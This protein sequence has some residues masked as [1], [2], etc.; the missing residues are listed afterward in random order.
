MHDTQN[1]TTVIMTVRHG[2]TDFNRQRRYAGLLDVSLNEDGIRDCQ[3]AAEFL[4]EPYDVVIASALK[5]SIETARLLVGPETPIGECVLCNE[6]NFGTM[7]GRTAREVEAIRPEIKYI[8]IADDFHCLNPPRGESLPALHRRAKEFFRYVMSNHRGAKVLIVSHEV[9]LQQF[10]GVLRGETWR[11]SM[12]HNVARLCL[13]V[14]ALRGSRVFRESGRSL[15]AEKEEPWYS[16]PGYPVQQPHV[17]I[18]ASVDGERR[19]TR[20]APRAL[21]AERVF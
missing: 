17:P 11:Q 18:F 10:H 3:A 16:G 15:T 4:R 8:K 1:G 19:G 7:Q 21:T 6:R 12:R 20:R 14:F 5:R 2:Q 9:F 13:S